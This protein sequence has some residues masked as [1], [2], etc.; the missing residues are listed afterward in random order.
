MFKTQSYTHTYIQ[1]NI[2][3]YIQTDRQTDRQMDRQTHIDTKRAMARRVRVPTH[4][5]RSHER[6]Q[7]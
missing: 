6:R 3:T 5:S 4:K 1:I 2:H 7:E